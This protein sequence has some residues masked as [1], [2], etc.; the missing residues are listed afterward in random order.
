MRLIFIQVLIFGVSLLFI[1]SI[2]LKK[3]VNYTLH[4]LER[5]ISL[6]EQGNYLNKSDS[7]ELIESLILFDTSKN[8]P[9]KVKRIIQQMADNFG[10]VMIG[11]NLKKTKIPDI[12]LVEINTIFPPKYYDPKTIVVLIPKLSYQGVVVK[13]LH[14][15]TFQGEKVKDNEKLVPYKFG[16]GYSSKNEINKDINVDKV[17]VEWVIL[18]RDERVSGS[19]RILSWP[20]RVN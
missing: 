20:E 15:I 11:V 13:E 14:S 3:P 12:L 18:Q 2:E 8:K 6:N 10:S 19:A 17:I 16:G 5:G 7:N 1:K 4:N 9:N